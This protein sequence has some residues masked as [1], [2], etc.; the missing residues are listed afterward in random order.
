MSD[1]ENWQRLRDA[2]AQRIAETGTNQ[3]AVS[4]AADLDE[5]TVGNLILGHVKSRPRTLRRIARALGW[6]EE[7]PELILAGAD[8]ADVAGEESDQDFIEAA[9]YFEGLAERPSIDFLSGREDASAEELLD[10]YE[11]VRSQAEAQELSSLAEMI[12]LR[13]LDEQ[14]EGTDWSVGAARKDWGADLYIADP[15]GEPQVLVEVKTKQRGF[16]TVDQAIGRAVRYG[17][18]MSRR[19]NRDVS[20]WIVFVEDPGPQVVEAFEEVDIPM[21]WIGHLPELPIG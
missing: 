3:R 1:N 19:W 20:Y 2:I 13:T 16:I 12:V 7:A 10:V 21:G 9:S 15:S 5:N 14:V 8:P 11:S 4:L 17:T 18:R 6:A